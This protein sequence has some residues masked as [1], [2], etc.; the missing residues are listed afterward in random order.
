MNIL[1]G[2]RGAGRGVEGASG[3]LGGGRERESRETAK[4]NETEKEREA[5]KD[6]R[7]VSEAKRGAG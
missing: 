1:G 6:C 4:K 2:K 5:Q 7:N 3:G